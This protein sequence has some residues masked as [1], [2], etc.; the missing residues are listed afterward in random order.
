MLRGHLDNATSFGYIEGWACDSADPTKALDVGVIWND[1]EVASG[2]A[3]RFREDLMSAD[4]GIGWCA[5]RLRLDVSLDDIQSGPVSLLARPSGTE[6]FTVK[7]IAVIVDGE[8]PIATL[9]ALTASDPTIIGGIWQLRRCEQLMM[10]FIRR[11]GVESFLDAAYAYVLG[12]PAD[13]SGR[14]KYARC[15]RQGTLTPV[16]ILEALGDSDEYRASLRQLAAPN[17]P[18]FPFV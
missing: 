8:E 18:G 4:F 7:E 17:A 12:H 1:T 10:Q 3:H 13:P 14:V 15:I 6:I 2:L 5:F 9:D 16:G 11:H